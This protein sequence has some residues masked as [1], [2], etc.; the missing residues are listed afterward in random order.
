[1]QWIIFAFLSS[2]VAFGVNKMMREADALMRGQRPNERFGNNHGENRPGADG[3]TVYR[4]RSAARKPAP[5]R[6]QDPRYQAAQ[7]LEQCP[8]CGIYA[9]A[10]KHECS[11]LHDKDNA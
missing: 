4:P 11:A 2:L 10:G 1:M 9:V 7:E 3:Y 5:K 8:R 6:A